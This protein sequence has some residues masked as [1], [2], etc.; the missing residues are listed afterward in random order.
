MD[1]TAHA[2]HSFWLYYL[3][4]YIWFRT[5]PSPIIGVF[6]IIFGIC[7]DFDSIYFILKGKNP[8][9]NTFQHHLYF[10]THVPLSYVFLIPIFLI[11]LVV[12]WHPEY[13]L[14]PIVGIYSH[15]LSDSAC[16]GDGMMWG[17]NPRNNKQ[18]APFFNFFSK[19]TD[20]YH[21]NFW[22][23]RW[24]RTKMYKIANING[25][26]IIIFMIWQIILL[27]FS[28]SALII[29]LY[30]TCSIIG[31]AVPVNP[32]YAQEPENGRYDDYRKNPD[33]LK[34]METNAYIFNE[35]MHAIRKKS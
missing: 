26:I 2:S 12:N 19:Q 18:F 3:I 32:K 34:W 5:F 23:I 24:R 31:G 8:K 6:M 10:W 33:Y 17:K 21:G 9:D 15:L 28:F 7:P 29:I 35:K 25:I 11:F 20:G 14:M 4:Y 13:F 27:G 16:C 1:S 22:S 30:F